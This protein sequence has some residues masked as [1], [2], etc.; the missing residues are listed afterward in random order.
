MHPVTRLSELCARAAPA[1][2]QERS[3]RV[4]QRSPYGRRPGWALRPV[5]V[6]SGDDCRQEALAMQLISAFDTLFQV[7][8]TLQPAGARLPC[9][10]SKMCRL[11]APW[12]AAAGL[13]SFKHASHR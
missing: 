9:P 3:E 6:K 4:R 12:H 13:P 11:P 8:S 10:E 2:F 1:R 5:M 7:R